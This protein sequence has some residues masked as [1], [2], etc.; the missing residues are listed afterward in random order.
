MRNEATI[1]ARAAFANT[2]VKITLVGVGR[3]VLLFKIGAL[4]IRFGCWL[5]NLG[6]EES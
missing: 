1:N 3:A 2:T 4:F 5:A 6:Y